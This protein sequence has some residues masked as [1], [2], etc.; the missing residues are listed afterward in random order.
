MFV[1][2]TD[3]TDGTWCTRQT[4]RLLVKRGPAIHNFL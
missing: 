1:S 3:N 2:G 4:D